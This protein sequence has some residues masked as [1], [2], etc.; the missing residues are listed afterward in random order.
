[1]KNRNLILSGIIITFS[2]AVSIFFLPGC[3]KNFL[4]ENPKDQVSEDIFW[5]TEQD[6]KE[7]LMGVYRG[8]VVTGWWNSSNGWN[9]VG[10][11]FSADWTDVGS[12][13]EVGSDYPT[14]G[15]I[16]T[17]PQV[18]DMWS[19]NYMIISRANNFLENI[20]KVNMNEGKRTEMIA[21]V[22]FLRAYSYFWLSQLYGNVPLIKKVLTFEEANSVT[23][24]S[25]D[26]VVNF[27]V[28]ELTEAANDLPI[29]RP[30]DENGRVE[31]GAALAL[32]GRF[33]M[34]EHKWSE[35]AKTYKDVIDL[36]RYTIDPRF[37]EL[38]EEAG[39]NSNEIIFAR[40]YTEG[41]QFGE[42]ITQQDAPPGWYGGYTQLTFYQNFVDEFLMTD[43]EPINQS[44]LYDP[45]NPFANRDPRLYATVLLPD[46]SVVNGKIYRGNPDSTTQTGPGV[47]GY[48]FNKFW[49]HNYT[50]NKSQYGGDYP[51]MRYAEVLLSYL[52]SELMSGAPITQDLLDE[53]IN[54]VRGREAVQMP[55]V[56]ETD[57]TKLMEIIKRERIVEF[58]CEGGIRYWDLVRWKDAVKALNRDFYGMK[59]TDNPAGYTGK[60]KIDNEGHIFIR[61]GKK[62][63]EYN[64]L[65]P[66]PQ[67]NLDV[68]KNL[69]Q[70]PGY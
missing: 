54:K 46:Y 39:D 34:A 24:S 16:S 30:I 26:T 69:K 7:A 32:K 61:A 20:G 63:N 62:F 70:N 5:K 56:T 66:I 37:K 25:Q 38:F 42:P 28:N 19:Y 44:P 59:I 52:E 11:L 49:D 36:N 57:P 3:K 18:N 45:Q 22:R 31:K 12:N 65:W 8:N 68:D 17:D 67:S 9:I 41:G 4:T 21:E 35:A 64:Y 48:G 50:G 53:T 13:K 14:S 15:I 60:Y 6:A 10:V 23:Q 40:K 58:A 1:M 55:K 43:G 27:A 29:K 33:L 2:T 47:T 51:L